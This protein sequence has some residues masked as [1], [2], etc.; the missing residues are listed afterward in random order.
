MVGAGCAVAFSAVVG[1]VEV[2]LA[3]VAPEA[4]VVFFPVGRPL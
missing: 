3:F 2:K 4:V 1:V